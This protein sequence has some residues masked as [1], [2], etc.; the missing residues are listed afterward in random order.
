M[1]IASLLALVEQSGLRWQIGSL[2][3]PLNPRRPRGCAV[4]RRIDLAVGEAEAE[5]ARVVRLRG[6]SQSVAGAVGHPDEAAA[7]RALGMDKLGHFPRGAQAIL[8][9]R[10]PFFDQLGAEA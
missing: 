4:D 10:D 2:R 6:V 8:K 1:S 9:S 5:L 3:R 7:Q